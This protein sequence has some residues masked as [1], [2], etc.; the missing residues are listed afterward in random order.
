MVNFKQGLIKKILIILLTL[1]IPVGGLIFLSRDINNRAE[2]IKKQRQEFVDRSEELS[3]FAKLQSQFTEA[4][5]YQGILGNVLPVRDQLFDF[6]K[7]IE[8]L[9]S[10]EGVGFGFSFGNETPSSSNTAGRIE[11]AITTGGSLSKIFKFI[12]AMEDSRFLIG[13]KSFDLSGS[14][15]NINGDVLFH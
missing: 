13:F 12:K 2:A 8:R 6:P 11:F 7:E 10:Q 4:N 1:L 5:S 9:A 15:V 3:L 14:S